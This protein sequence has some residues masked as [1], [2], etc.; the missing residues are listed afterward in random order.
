MF[1]LT[2]IWLGLVLQLVLVL[3]NGVR[4]SFLP[5]SSSMQST[6][7]VLCTVSVWRGVC[8]YLIILAVI[9]KLNPNRDPQTRALLRLERTMNLLCH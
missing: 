5:I 9:A 6:C 3:E 1:G 7:G 4:H 8:G 2:F